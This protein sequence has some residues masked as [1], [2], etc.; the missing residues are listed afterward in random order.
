MAKFKV[1]YSS[2]IVQECEQ[3]DCFTV[4]QFINCRF[5]TCDTS[6]AK[7]ELVGE[8]PVEAKPAKKA[9]KK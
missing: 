8:E 4:E 5:G 9:T 3:S 7:V 1:I 6:S 2:G